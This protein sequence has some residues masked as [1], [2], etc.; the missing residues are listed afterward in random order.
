MSSQHQKVVSAAGQF[1]KRYRQQH[2]LTQEQLATLLD[3][4]PRTVRAYENGE[5]RLTNIRDLYRIADRLGVDPEQLG[6]HRQRPAPQTSEEVEEL[7]QHAWNLMEETRLSESRAVIEQLIQTMPSG[8]MSLLLPITKALYAAGYIVS[9]GVRSQESL[10]AIHYYRQME[11]TAR[12]LED[13][14]LINLALTYQGDM[15]RR[16]GAL[17]RAASY[18]EAARD[19]TPKAV[20]MVRGNGL[21]LLARVY[22]R[23]GRMQEFDRAMKEAEAIAHRLDPTSLSIPLHYNLTAVYEEYARSYADL[24]KIKPALYYIDAAQAQLPKNRFWE[25]VLETA[26]VIAL[27]KGGEIEEGIALSIPLAQE[28]KQKGLLRFLDRLYLIDTYLQDLENKIGRS[29]R[30]LTEALEM[31]AIDY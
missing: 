16:L 14:T 17:A 23:Q 1:L 24:G 15:Y 28:I 21:Q 3:V 20:E 25:L 13:D 10:Q 12:L 4:E 29:R 22:L 7:L 2:R 31:K 19:T 26:R 18:L 30:R 8:N 5:R 11:A 6:L 27:V 9:E